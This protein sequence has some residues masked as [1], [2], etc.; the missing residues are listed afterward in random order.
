MC[1]VTHHINTALSR[2]ICHVTHHINTTQPA[3]HIAGDD[4][5]ARPQDSDADLEPAH[6]NGAHAN[7]INGHEEDAM[8]T[9]A[10]PPRIVEV[11]AAPPNT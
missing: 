8:E 2:S 11:V 5:A 10:V 4:D 3:H 7:G 6:A 1:H 9:D